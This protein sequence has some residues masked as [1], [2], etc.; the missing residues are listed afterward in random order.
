MHCASAVWK[1]EATA[2]S[3]LVSDHAF[4]L[5]PLVDLGNV[6]IV[7]SRLPPSVTIKTFLGPLMD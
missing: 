2:L 7:T 6:V 1:L 3:K 5:S 4:V